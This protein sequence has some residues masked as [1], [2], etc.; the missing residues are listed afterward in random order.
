MFVPRRHSAPQE[1]AAGPSIS[2]AVEYYETDIATS[3]A[4]RLLGRS[5]AKHNLVDMP[6]RFA[7]RAG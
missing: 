5:A 3:G 4:I 1:T 2:H 7:G 6:P